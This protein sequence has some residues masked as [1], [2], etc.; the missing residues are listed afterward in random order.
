M[1]RYFVD[2]MS[3][4]RPD[5]PPT[6]L[7]S[8]EVSRPVHPN[9]LYGHTLT[10]PPPQ[11]ECHLTT[12]KTLQPYSQ[13]EKVIASQLAHRPPNKQHTSTQFKFKFFNQTKKSKRKKLHCAIVQPMCFPRAIGFLLPSLHVCTRSMQCT[14]RSSRPFDDGRD[15]YL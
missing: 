7:Y 12:S 8:Y 15:G 2:H 11:K 6:S 13:K 1:Q 4:K 5:L 9:A 10:K 3:T 14:T